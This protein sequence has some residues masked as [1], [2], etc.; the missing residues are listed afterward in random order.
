MNVTHLLA[1][2]VVV[3][4]ATIGIYA[5]HD[6]TERCEARHGVLVRGLMGYE[7]IKAVPA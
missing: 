1:I 3:L 5:L 7:C 2:V 4:V 6:L